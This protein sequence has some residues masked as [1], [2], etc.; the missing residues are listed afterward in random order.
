MIRIKKENLAHFREP[1]GVS[2]RKAGCSASAP[3]V[4]GFFH[5]GRSNIMKKI[6]RT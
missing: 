3:P 4:M 6:K 5:A 1:L 2:P